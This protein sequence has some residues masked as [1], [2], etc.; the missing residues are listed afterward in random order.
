MR[1]LV[2]EGFGVLF[3]THDIQ[4]VLEIGDYVTVLRDGHSVTSGPVSTYTRD[5][6]VDHLAG[7]TGTDKARSST[8]EAKEISSSEPTV[9]S[10]NGIYG[11]TLENVNIDV[12]PGEI[13]GV[14]GLLGSGLDEL[15][16]IAS[17]RMPFAKGSAVY[18]GQIEPRWGYNPRLSESIGFVPGH[19][20]TQSVLHRLTVRENVSIANL[21]KYLRLLW[22]SRKLEDSDVAN[23]LAR[24]QVVPREMEIPL[25]MLS[26]GN[27]QKALLARWL[28]VRPD[29]LVIEGLTQGI[30]V[31]SKE[32]VLRIVREAAE[33]KMGLLLI[34]YEFEEISKACDR[35]LLL[36]H[37]KIIGELRPPHITNET[38][39]RMIS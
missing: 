34:S 23:W 9:L 16:H 4:E 6:L 17:S 3:V 10:L 14:T 8:K 20:E 22:I 29:L 30:D 39:T 38:I 19:R 11:E 18:A 25:T 28:S 7:A 33:T 26:G 12:K 21:K 37:G 15:A 36:R 1:L 27:Q 5:L 13:V 31:V 24:L 32:E 2:A 35:L